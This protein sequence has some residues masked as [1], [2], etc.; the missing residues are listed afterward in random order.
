MCAS[1]ET[2]DEDR[3]SMFVVVP[4]AVENPERMGLWFIPSLV[5]LVGLEA[6]DGVYYRLGEALD[7]AQGFIKPIGFDADREGEFTQVPVGD[8]VGFPNIP[9]DIIKHRPEIMNTIPCKEAQFCRDFLGNLE[10][11]P[12]DLLNSITIFFG[13]HFM[14][15]SIN[16]LSKPKVEV[17]DAA[18]YP[19]EA[20]S[21]YFRD[22]RHEQITSKAK[23]TQK[24]KD[25]KSQT[26]P[27]HHYGVRI[28]DFEYYNTLIHPNTTEPYLL[29]PHLQLSCKSQVGNTTRRNETRAGRTYGTTTYA[30]TQIKW[31]APVMSVVTLQSLYYVKVPVDVHA[32]TLAIFSN[33]SI[34]IEAE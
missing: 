25:V 17:V 6:S 8:I 23:D 1:K 26:S 10:F 29:P 13:H 4:E 5:C 11:E 19:R 7:F 16:K 20:V 12:Q 31:R 33:V 18:V 34:H 32:K 24:F 21:Q 14:C 15:Y 22:G 27:G 2:Q 28:R 9:E 30:T 3:S